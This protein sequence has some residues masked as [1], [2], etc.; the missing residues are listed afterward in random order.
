MTSAQK[1]LAFERR[2]R[3]PRQRGCSL[4]WPADRGMYSAGSPCSIRRPYLS[5]P[6][7]S[8]SCVMVSL[9]MSSSVGNSCS[10]FSSEVWIVTHCVPQDGRVEVYTAGGSASQSAVSPL[11]GWA[12]S[13]TTLPPEAIKMLL[14]NDHRVD[15][16]RLNRSYLPPLKVPHLQQ[17]THVEDISTNVNDVAYIQYSVSFSQKKKRAFVLSASVCSWFSFFELS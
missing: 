12:R 9:E 11:R 3:Q 16:H 13:S 10:T 15:L 14:R 17:A 8:C 4:L 6:R 2:V 7:G 1:R 5:G